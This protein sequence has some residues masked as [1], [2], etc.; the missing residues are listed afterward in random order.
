MAT[1]PQWWENHTLFYSNNAGHDFD[2]FRS[3]I[4]RASSELMREV[5]PRGTCRYTCA[6]N[7]K[8]SKVELQRDIKRT[9]L[10]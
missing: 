1:V 2:S 7:L 5:V 3:I 8:K 6:F 4:I 9:K 10:L